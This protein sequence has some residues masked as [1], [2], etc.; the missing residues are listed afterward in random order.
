MAPKFLSGFSTLA[1]IEAQVPKK[2]EGVLFCVG[3]ISA[4]YTVFMDKGYLHAEYNAL[5][6]NRYKIRSDA[7][8]P[9]GKV[10]IAVETKFD[11]PQRE[12]PATVTFRVNGKQVGQGRIGRSVPAAFTASETFDVG[13]DLGSPVS[14]DY[15]DRAPFK[16]T[17]RIEKINI[18]YVP[19][20]TASRSADEALS[21]DLRELQPA[22][23]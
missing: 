5:T 8:I 20:T 3:G 21:A 18:R 9:T 1:T 4:G 17:G 19:S 2:A 7:P 16:F 14:L 23:S 10:T 12:A 6:L 22:I 15:H 13:M 11:G